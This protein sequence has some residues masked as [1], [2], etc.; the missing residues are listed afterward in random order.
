MLPMQGFK[1]CLGAARAGK[2]KQY[3]PRQVLVRSNFSKM[4][5]TN[6]KVFIFRL[7]K[8]TINFLYPPL[9]K[10]FILSISSWDMKTQSWDIFAR[11]RTSKCIGVCNHDGSLEKEYCVPFF[12][13]K[14]LIPRY[15]T[16]IV[17]ARAFKH[18]RRK[19]LRKFRLGE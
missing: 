6:K 10:S 4:D 15:I 17:F 7:E 18:L 14:F 8:C 2:Q 5:R 1:D 12:K 16:Y 3:S 11:V 9:S 13:L 19:W